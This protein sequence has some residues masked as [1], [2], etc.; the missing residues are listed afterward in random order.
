[1]TNLTCLSVSAMNSPDIF[2]KF[3]NLYFLDLVTV[4][5]T[6]GAEVLAALPL[7]TSL[8]ALDMSEQH[9]VPIS[10]LS[11]LTNLTAINANARGEVTEPDL[12][13]DTLTKLKYFSAPK[14]HQH[15]GMSGASTVTPEFWYKKVLTPIKNADLFRCMWN[16]V[17]ER[18]DY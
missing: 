15:L 5:G 2:T 9:L 16:F 6:R 18:W 7:V 12:I 8:Q 3:S 13:P 17:D 4:D 11:E 14:M 10:A 1:M